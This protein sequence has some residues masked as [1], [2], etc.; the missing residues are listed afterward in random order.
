MTFGDGAM[1][2]QFGSLS[3]KHIQFIN[4]QHLFFVCTAAS[5]GSVNQHGLDRLPTEII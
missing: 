4:G 1:A 3:E 2:D 5:E